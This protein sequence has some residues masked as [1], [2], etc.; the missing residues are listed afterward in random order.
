LLIEVEG[1]RWSASSSLFARWFVFPTALPQC[2][3]PQSQQQFDQCDLLDVRDSKLWP[4]EAANDPNQPLDTLPEPE[5]NR[6]LTGIYDRMKKA[7]Q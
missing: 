7:I 6:V 3:R 5:Q 4:F 1:F 2:L